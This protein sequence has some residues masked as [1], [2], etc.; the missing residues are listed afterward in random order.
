LTLNGKRQLNFIDN[1]NL[2]F[3]FWPPF[4]VLTRFQ[5]M[6]R[7][8]VSRKADVVK[9]IKNNTKMIMKKFTY[10]NE[11]RADFERISGGINIGATCVKNYW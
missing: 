11:R 6:I 1:H 2:S 8:I 4:N 10:F 3:I 9:I 7:Q 5:E